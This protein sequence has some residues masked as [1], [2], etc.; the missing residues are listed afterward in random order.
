MIIGNERMAAGCNDVVDLLQEAHKEIDE[1]YQNND[2]DV[3]INL[4]LKYKRDKH[5]DVEM[6]TNINFV[7]VRYKNKIK[8]VVDEG[9]RPLPGFGEQP[10]V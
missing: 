9:Q 1:A 4:T 2:N 10:E 3:G 5:G 7:Q 8:R 6:E